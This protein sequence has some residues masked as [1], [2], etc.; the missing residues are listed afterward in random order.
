MSCFEFIF[1]RPINMTSGQQSLGK[2]ST[3]TNGNSGS[4]TTALN[5]SHE[6]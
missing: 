3:T 1:I 5:Q 4:K 2:M 6:T